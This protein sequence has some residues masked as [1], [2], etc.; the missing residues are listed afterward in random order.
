M[1]VISVSRGTYEGKNWCKVVFIGD[2][3]TDNNS[4][5]NYVRSAK[6]D[7]KLYDDLVVCCR[8]QIEVQPRCDFY[9]KVVALDY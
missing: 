3:M 7:Y 4:F 9:G 5:G 1:R 2:S 6:A 8:D